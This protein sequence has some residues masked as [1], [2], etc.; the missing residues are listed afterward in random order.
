MDDPALQQRLRRIEQRQYL[1]IALLVVP[2]LY[3]LGDLVGFYVAAV[4]GVA[5]GLFGFVAIAI[6]RR[7]NR[8][9]A[10]Q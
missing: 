2:Y 3:W 8:N 7:R 9:T 1:L 4:L 10:G 5:L 6:N